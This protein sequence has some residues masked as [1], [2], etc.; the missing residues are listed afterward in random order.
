MPQI[1]NRGALGAVA[2]GQEQASDYVVEVRA[3]VGAGVDKMTSPVHSSGPHEFSGIDCREIGSLLRF[4]GFIA[5]TIGST[6]IQGDP[7]PKAFFPADLNKGPSGEELRGFVILRRHVVFAY[8][9][10]GTRSWWAKILRYDF[11]G[12]QLTSDDFSCDS[13]G[14]ALYLSYCGQTTGSGSAPAGTRT[15]RCDKADFLKAGDTFMIERDTGRA[16]EAIADSVSGDGTV[17]TRSNLRFSHGPAAYAIEGG[18]GK[19]GMTVVTHDGTDFLIEQ[20]GPLY[21]DGEM[22]FDA[23]MIG[24]TTTP[25]PTTTAPPLTITHDAVHEGDP[26][27]GGTVGD[28]VTVGVNGD[29][30]ETQFNT[31]GSWVTYNPV[32]QPVQIKAAADRTWKRVG[33]PTQSTKAGF[34]FRARVRR[35]GAG[36]WTYSNEVTSGAAPPDPRSSLVTVTGPIYGG[37]LQLRGT[38]PASAT[39]TAEAAGVVKSETGDNWLIVGKV[40]VVG[41]GLLG[42]NTFIIDLA[43]SPLVKGRTYSVRSRDSA[44]ADWSGD[45]LGADGRLLSISKVA[46]ETFST[47]AVINEPVKETDAK[48]NGF[49]GDPHADANSEGQILILDATNNWKPVTAIMKTGQFGPATFSFDRPIAATEGRIITIRTRVSPSGPWSGSLD[50]GDGR[51]WSIA[52]KVKA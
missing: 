34:K 52:V 4:P 1:S 29:D 36:P 10:T 15:L 14:V 42:S 51:L 23:T 24:G 13:S 2:G 25:P 40:Q 41:T 31:T 19:V 9:D 35:D 48:V 17:T 32:K 43:N 16:E 27:V 45:L 3:W 30:I 5:M 39:A 47:L 20:A 21:E 12:L 11:G 8:W 44:T 28:A 46:G 6:P 7:S 22:E 18:S 37:D 26:S 33:M 38:M 50:G 49:L